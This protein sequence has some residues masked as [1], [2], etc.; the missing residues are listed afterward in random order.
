MIKMEPTK[1]EKIE[2][3]RLRLISVM[4][5]VDQVVDRVLFGSWQQTEIVR[6]MSHPGKAGWTPMPVGYYSLL[7][8]FPEN[9][10]ATDCS[11]FDWTFPSWLVSVI[12]QSR[13]DRMKSSSETFVNAAWARWLEVLGRD[14]VMRL[15][16]GSRY[17]QTELGIMKSGWLLT[18]S[19]N[20]EAQDKLSLLAYKRA[21]GSADMPELWSMG[22]DVL[23]AWDDKDPSPFQEALGTTGILTKFA[24]HSR[25]FAGFSFIRTALGPVVNPLY[26][27]KH[28]FI[29][30]HVAREDLTEVLSAYGCLYALADKVESAWV[31]DLV[32]AYG[33]WPMPVYRAWA[34][35]LLPR[36]VTL[37]CTGDAAG[38]LRF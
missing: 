31:L 15:P 12:F 23:M 20:S 33:R 24:V 28:A 1:V 36:N 32:R 34:V 18:I 8:T 6:C 37:V 26:P 7:A 29:L 27:A 14:C 17:A 16:D 22:D 3:G 4:S 19:V 13:V 35:G 21:Y 2:E 25:E 9:V 10:L 11:A 5:L 30:R 38:F